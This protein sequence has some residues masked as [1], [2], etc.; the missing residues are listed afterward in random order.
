VRTW[1]TRAS[2]IV[3][4]ALVASACGGT[5]A[6]S[7]VTTTPTS[8]AV[9]LAPTTTTTMGEFIELTPN[10]PVFLT[11][12]DRSEYVEAL[13]F[14][15]VCTG[16]DQIT[17]DGGSVSVDGVF[18]PI[19]SAM[20]AYVQAEMRRVPSGS[21][22]EATFASLSRRCGAIRTVEFAGD[23]ADRRIGGNVAPGDDD[24]LI[25]AGEIGRTLTVELVEGTVQ[26]SV[27]NEAGN[28]MHDDRDGPRWSAVLSEDGDYRIRVSRP[29]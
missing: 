4:L 12:G 26:F 2:L 25:V 5:S 21:P 22:D 23:R 29:R 18:G 13:Q 14:Y 8:A 16:H 1:W 7:P 15:L 27:R 6:L 3:A 28:V 24:L 17:E 9:T 20:V 19:T 10:G 11:Q